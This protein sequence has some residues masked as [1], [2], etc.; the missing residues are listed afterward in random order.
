MP[1]AASKCCSRPGR[2][3]QPKLAGLTSSSL[4]HQ[5]QERQPASTLNSE[6]ILAWK[7]DQILYYYFHLA[8]AII[9]NFGLPLLFWAL[10]PAIISNF[11]LRYYFDFWPPLLFRAL[12]SAI[13]LDFGPRHHFRF[14][15]VYYSELWPPREGTFGSIDFAAGACVLSNIFVA[16]F[17]VS[18]LTACVVQNSRNMLFC[19]P[20][21]RTATNRCQC[22]LSR[23]CKK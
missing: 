4:G 15:R 7:M 23:I 21:S 22:R 14:W 5:P 11:G 2:P 8:S 1:E 13:I 3:D 10:A 20:V 6:L 9:S 12:A 18:A 16:G 19:W 17:V